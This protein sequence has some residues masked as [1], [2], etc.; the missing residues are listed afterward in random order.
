MTNTD[1]TNIQNQKLFTEEEFSEFTFVLVKNLEVKKI[2][3]EIAKEKII[4]IQNKSERN[5]K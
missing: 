4:L 3:K 2:T 5:T 1:E